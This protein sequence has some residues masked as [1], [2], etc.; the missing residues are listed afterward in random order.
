VRFENVIFKNAVKCLTKSQFS[1]Y[2]SV[3]KK[4]IPHCPLFENA[5][6]V[7]FQI[8]IFLK[9]LIL[10]ISDSANWFKIVFFVYEIAMPNIP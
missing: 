4:K 7:H 1:L 10:N 9:S 3:F 2:K 5:D 6:F 8:T